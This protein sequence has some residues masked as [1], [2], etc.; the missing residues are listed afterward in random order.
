MA[1]PL[2]YMV[3]SPSILNWF[4]PT[5]N[6]TGH[7]VCATSS[8]LRVTGDVYRLWTV[9]ELESHFRSFRS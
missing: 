8:H 1:R 4:C 5:V 7:S 6:V 2:G 9:S 3:Y